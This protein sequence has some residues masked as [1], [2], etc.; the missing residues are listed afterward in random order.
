MESVRK[1]WD[2]KLVTTTK[3]EIIWYPNQIIIQKVFLK[4]SNSNK[5]EY[6][7]QI[8]MNKPVYLGLSILE[9]MKSCNV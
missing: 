7:T 2:I 3:K 8:F 5:N 6:R 9:V 1:H 4:N